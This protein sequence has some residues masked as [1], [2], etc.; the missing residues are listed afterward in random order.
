MTPKQIAEGLS[1]DESEAVLY[2]D[3][4]GSYIARRPEAQRLNELGLLSPKFDYAGCTWVAE[5][6]RKIVTGYHPTPLGREV[7]E[8]LKGM[9]K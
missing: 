9:T 8:I 2:A 5:H 7:A 1:E 3:R 4:W 6:H